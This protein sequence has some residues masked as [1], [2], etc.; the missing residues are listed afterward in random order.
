MSLSLAPCHICPLAGHLNSGVPQAGQAQQS[1]LNSSSFS[2]VLHLSEVPH[3]ISSPSQK[4][5]RYLRHFPVSQQPHRVI[6]SLPCLHSSMDN[7]Y[8]QDDLQSS[9]SFK[10]NFPVYVFNLVSHQYILVFQGELQENTFLSSFH[11]LGCK[12]SRCRDSVSF[13]TLCP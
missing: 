2:C 4:P 7:C 8:P 10:N 11:T 9:L 13:L 6:M 5:V 3:S 12:L 1:E